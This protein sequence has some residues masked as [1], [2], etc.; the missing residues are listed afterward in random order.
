MFFK[1]KELMG[2]LISVLILSFAFMYSFFN[3]IGFFIFS[4]SLL[5]TGFSFGMKEL[6]H[7]S[8]AK[9]LGYN[10]N[11]K[12]W[13]PG[14]LLAAVSSFFPIVFT[15]PGYTEVKS[16][17]YDHLKKKAIHL[18]PLTGELSVPSQEGIIAYFGPLVNI[19]IGAGFMT[20]LTFNFI[21]ISVN[22]IKFA[23]YINF[24]IA[25]FNLL[26][27]SKLDGIKV[28]NWNAGVWLLSEFLSVFGIFMVFFIL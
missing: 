25:F 11:F 16:K 13:S 12:L 26:P 18:G 3:R 24:L 28:I 14:A 4:I 19:A 2:I 8:I 9:D 23:A 5:V 15:A 10:T 1:D 21:L 7:S 6:A 20:F 17:Y 22:I 27:I